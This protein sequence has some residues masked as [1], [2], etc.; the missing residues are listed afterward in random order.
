M[1]KQ[2]LWILGIGFHWKH[3]DLERLWVLF[4]SFLLFEKRFV[5]SNGWQSI[6]GQI[7]IGQWC[8]RVLRIQIRRYLG[9][10]IVG[11]WP[12]KHRS[13]CWRVEKTCDSLRDNPR[14]YSVAMYVQYGLHSMQRVKRM[15]KLT[16][17]DRHSFIYKL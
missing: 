6:L 15:R 3:N 11:N 7:I 16:A 10:V 9:H 8:L 17:R 2:H 14:N 5:K 12:R 13:Q 4:F 1:H